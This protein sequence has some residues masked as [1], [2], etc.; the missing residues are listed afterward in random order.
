MDL[1]REDA[2]PGQWLQVQGGTTRPSVMKGA[3]G[4]VARLALRDDG[5][6]RLS[7]AAL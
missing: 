5:R 6:V 2:P 3:A 7:G 4:P 1:V